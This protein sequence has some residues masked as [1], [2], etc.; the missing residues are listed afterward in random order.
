[1]ECSNET[2]KHTRKGH[3]HCSCYVKK[4]RKI[5]PLICRTCNA[6]FYPKQG[7]SRTTCENPRCHND[8]RGGGNAAWHT[9]G[10]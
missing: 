5:T 3:K 9:I 4:K 1:M 6:K 7:R 10:Q 2:V 8:K